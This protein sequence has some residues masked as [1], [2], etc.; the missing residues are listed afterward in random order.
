[1]LIVLPVAK[2]KPASKR[3]IWPSCLHLGSVKIVDSRSGCA[4]SAITFLNQVL[5]NGFV[6]SLSRCEQIFEKR[7]A[8]YE[9]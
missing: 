2:A 4:I 7:Y 1:L 8:V 3:G 5:E 6:A 9:P